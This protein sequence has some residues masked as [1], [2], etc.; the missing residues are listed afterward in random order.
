[1][2][3]EE[4]IATNVIRLRKERGLNQTDLARACRMAQAQVSAV[5]T[6]KKTPT[7]QTLEK[8]ARALSIEPFELLMPN[9]DTGKSLRNKLLQIENLAP[10]RRAALEVTIDLFLEESARVIAKKGK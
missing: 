8:L 4:I 5:E 7:I 6:A 9:D 3:L 1:M 2:T 10:D